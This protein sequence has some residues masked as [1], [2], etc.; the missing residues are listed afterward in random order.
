MIECTK[1]KSFQKGTLQGFADF[2]IPKWGVELNGC[3]L[4]MK[5][6][7]RWINFPSKEFDDNGEKKFAPLFKFRNKKHWEAF[8]EEGKRAIEK[9]CAENHELPSDEYN[10]IEVPF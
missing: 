5:D 8:I 1:F 10:N 4:H 6:G 2:Y 3:T 9:Y 7:K